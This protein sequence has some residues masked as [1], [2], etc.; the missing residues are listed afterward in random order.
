MAEGK[1]QAVYAGGTAARAGK[2]LGLVLTGAALVGGGLLLS[3]RRALIGAAPLPPVEAKGIFVPARTQGEVS[4][5]LHPIESVQASQSTRVSFGIPFPR[6]FMTD[7]HMLRLLDANRQEMRIHTRMLSPWRDLGTLQMIPSARSMLVQAE[8]TFTDSNGDGRPDPVTLIAEWGRT[9]RERERDFSFVPVRNTWVPVSDERYP[10]SARVQEPKAYAVFTPEWYGQCVIKNRVLPLGAHPAFSTYDT[11][12]RL[13]A[14]TA[15]NRVDPRVHEKNK[16][17]FLTEYDAWLFDRPSTLYQL[18]FRT[19]E[20]QWLRE[21]HRASQYYAT[22]IG[23]DG[24]LDLK[25]ED[26]KYSY[27]ECLATNYWLTGDEANLD[28]A[29]RV[30]GAWRKH[31]DIYYTS[32]NLE[33]HWTE[34]HAGFKLAALVVGY[35]LTGDEATGREAKQAF[36]SLV[37]MQENP[38]PGAPRTPGALMHTALSHGD[39]DNNEIIASPWMSTLLVDAVQR[40]YTH[41]ADPRVPR[42]VTRMA[43]FFKSDVSL[44]WSSEYDRVRRLFPYYLAQTDKKPRAEVWEDKEHPL[45]TSKIFAL[46]YFFSKIEGRPDDSY[47]TVMSDLQKTQ[48]ESTFLDWLRP[49]A[50]VDG[51]TVFRVGPPRK[52][53]WWFRTTA[54]IDWLI[55]AETPLR[56][57]QNVN[58]T[59]LELTLTADKTSV[60]P[61]DEI[62]YTLKYR[63]TTGMDAGNVYLRV[64]VYL[65]FIAGRDEAQIGAITGGGKETSNDILWKV[66]DVRGRTGGSVSFRLRVKSYPANPSSNRPISPIITRAI[67]YY[68]RAGHTVFNGC[69]ALN[70]EG[71]SGTYCHSSVSGMAVAERLGSTDRYR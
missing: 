35:E 34:R 54:D 19:G 30:L 37:R 46:A 13:M 8:V 71:A 10:S 2:A 63:N 36:D 6:G 52:F 43:D 68:C 32:Q 45:D 23:P 41:S 58:S 25:E 11:M 51:L 16:I 53:G 28:A 26:V 12:F 66:G 67:A 61:G 39:G 55:G 22:H 64:P 60:R 47:L 15:V 70:V 49:L 33:R 20:L 38:I 42:F 14:D 4:F 50:P 18:A 56:E 17:P 44:Y 24:L 40:Y 5:K 65:T 62:G 59:Q 57:S 9:R 69:T 1:M 7:P 3:G 48:N 21:A 29:E 27:A 31:F